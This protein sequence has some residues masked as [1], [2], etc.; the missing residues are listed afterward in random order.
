[1]IGPKDLEEFTNKVKAEVDPIK[2]AYL[3]FDE[4]QIRKKV[5]DLSK[6]DNELPVLFTI[7]PSALR[8]GGIDYHKWSN[9]LMFLILDKFDDNDLSA[10]E[11]I[12]KM[13]EI[14][15]STVGF[16]DFLNSQVE[17]NCNFLKNW[18]GK[19]LVEPEYQLFDCNGYSITLETN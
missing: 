13:N 17:N 14:H 11:E 18:D 16:L 10:S 12:I 15:L 4:N 9:Y 19:V 1:M 3:I 8:D 6:S 5:Q 7:L 2:S